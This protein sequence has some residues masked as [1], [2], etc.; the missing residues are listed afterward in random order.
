MTGREIVSL[1]EQACPQVLSSS[2]QVKEWLI[3]VYTDMGWRRVQVRGGDKSRCCL[4]RVAGV[5][6]C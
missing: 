2:L 5:E 6:V 4:M 3:Y 1:M